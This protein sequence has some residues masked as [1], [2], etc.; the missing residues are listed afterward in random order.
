MDNIY[1][2]SQLSD[3]EKD[4]YLAGY[5]RAMTEMNEMKKALIEFIENYVYRHEE[6]LH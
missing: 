3:K 5:E 6:D 4:I 2:T 1:D